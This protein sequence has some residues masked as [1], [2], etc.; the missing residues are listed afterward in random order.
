MNVLTGPVKPSQLAALALDNSMA[1]PSCLCAAVVVVAVDVSA[2]LFICHDNVTAAASGN[3]GV[4]RLNSD[5]AVFQE[6][7]YFVKVIGNNH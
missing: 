3:R 7:R 5:R 4:G 1:K 6:V 2:C